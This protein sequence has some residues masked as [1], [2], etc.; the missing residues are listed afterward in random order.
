VDSCG[1]SCRPVAGCCG[2]DRESVGSLK[3]GEFLT[4][5]REYW[6]L[7][8]ARQL[9]VCDWVLD[10]ISVRIKRSVGQNEMRE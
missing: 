9:A 8:E 3:C 10:S 6:R 5:V 7:K 1:F 4:Y 2:P